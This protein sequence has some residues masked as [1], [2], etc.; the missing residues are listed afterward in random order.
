MYTKRYHKMSGALRNGG[1]LAIPE[2][3]LFQRPDIQ[4]AI[5]KEYEVEY[6][7]SEQITDDKA[8]II[9]NIPR[10]S[11][12]FTDLRNSRL[13]MKL[14]MKHADGTKLEMREEAAVI[15]LIHQTAWSQIDVTINGTPV[16]SNTRLFPYKAFFKTLTRSNGISDEAFM[17]SM[18]W[19]P[20]YNDTDEIVDVSYEA[21]KKRCAN[22]RMIE[23]EGPLLE[24]IFE[25]QRYLLN[26]IDMQIKLHR[27]LMSFMLVQHFNQEK[28]DVEIKVLEDKKKSALETFL[29]DI[30]NVVKED[31]AEA[32]AIAYNIA[33]G[34]K[35]GYKIEL[36][37]I[38]MKMAYVRIY[39][40]VIQA[41]QETIELSP[42]LYPFTKTELKTVSIPTGQQ[43]VYFDTVFNGVRPSKM[44]MGFVSSEAMNGTI[45]TNPLD[46]KSY[47][48]SDISL[49]VDGSLIQPKKFTY[50]MTDI[51][52]IS[53]FTGAYTDYMKMVQRSGYGTPNISP[54]QFARNP[55]FAFSLEPGG[56]GEFHNQ[57]MK[58]PIAI[59]V[60]F[61]R[62]LSQS[63]N[64]VLYAEM[65]GLMQ[66]DAARNVAVN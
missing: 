60:H 7:P 12:D 55:L 59:I 1:R 62:P 25:S 20:P 38:V 32:A 51:T 52:D 58:G 15:N 4:D 28:T 3:N 17:K 57:A 31:A 54:E 47:Y 14:R 40:A 9:F 39:P 13:K 29:A 64:L 66:V 65:P 30:H 10:Q 24:D 42:A 5:E 37:D 33:Q 22:S 23:L 19:V 48:V 43:Q 36:V 8:P 18:G 45:T 11:R 27:S 2:L 35:K 50:N 53:D 46:F 63:V 61:D 56:H 49:M 34:V 26:G 41:I 6:R 21:S 44:L 16:S